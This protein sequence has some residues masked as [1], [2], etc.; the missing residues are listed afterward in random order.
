VK[1]K[2][3]L[4]VISA[5]LKLLGVLTCLAGGVKSFSETL[6]EQQC[7]NAD[8]TELVDSIKDGVVRYMIG[9]ASSAA[10]SLTLAPMSMM[11]GGRLIGLPYA[12]VN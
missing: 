10:G 8:G 1:G 2:S 3:L 9:V 6:V 5:C 4:N 7:F 12:R 11:W